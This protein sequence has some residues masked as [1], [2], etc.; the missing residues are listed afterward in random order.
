MLLR[1]IYDSRLAHASYLIGC[2]ETGTAIV[3]DP[4]RNVTPYVQLAQE[5]G[6][7]IVAVTET[8]I[9][10][11]FVSGVRELAHV[12][13]A[14]LYLSGMGGREWQYRFPDSDTI[15]LLGDGDV[16][17]IGNVKLQAMHT[18]GH[19]P[20]HLCFL[21]TDTLATSVPMGIL[22]GDCLFVGD[23]GRPDL[24]EK[25]VN[26]TES[27]LKGARQQFVNLQRLRAMPDYIQILPAHGAGSACGKAL[28]AVPS[29]TLGYEKLVNPAFQFTSESA[30]IAWLLDGQPEPPRYFAQMKQVNQHGATLLKDLPQPQHIEHAE[31]VEIVPENA[32]FLDTRPA[33]HYARYHLPRTVNIPISNRNFSTYVGWFVRYDQPVFFVAYPNDVQEVIGELFEIGVDDVRG[34]FH[35]QVARTSS[36]MTHTLTPREVYQKGLRIIDIRN[37]DE[38]AQERIPGSSAV[39]MGDIPASIHRLPKDEPI[40]IQC[41]TGVRS[42]IVTSLLESLGVTNAVTMEGGI[43]AWMDEGL[44]IEG[45]L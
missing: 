40:V 32:L 38:I 37:E 8:H 27:S 11:D 39:H 23:V 3:V 34:Y 17:E 29:S 5:E 14:T 20:E 1:T 18:P 15:T 6:L 36:L 9:H 45:S 33:A 21:L 19:T 44:P 42:A 13:G 10:A 31:D 25:V 4:S 22:S 16:I 41:A 12:T 2:Q 7:S 28:G 26:V 35:A 43:K 30:F 24:L